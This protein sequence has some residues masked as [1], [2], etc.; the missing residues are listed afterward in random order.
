MVSVV[1][2]P[3]SFLILFIWVI[4]LFFLVSLA[5]AFSVLFILLRNKLLVLLIFF[6]LFFISILFIS[7]L[8]FIIFFLLLSIGFVCFLILL[9]GR[10]GWVVG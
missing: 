4:S 10:L 5:R 3:L 6:L 9:G 7:S 1:I 8:I 2:S